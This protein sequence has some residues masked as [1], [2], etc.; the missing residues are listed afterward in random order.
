VEV[1]ALEPTTM[2]VVLDA[3]PSTS[4]SLVL[5]C[6]EEA[7]PRRQRLISK[8]VRPSI[9]RLSSGAKHPLISLEGA[10]SLLL[11]ALEKNF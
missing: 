7:E 9:F 1:A 3:L 8:N 10:T 4:S 5:T 2:E 11:Q 6:P